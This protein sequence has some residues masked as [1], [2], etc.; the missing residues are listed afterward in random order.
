MPDFRPRGALTTVF[1][2]FAPRQEGGG[3]DLDSRPIAVFSLQANEWFGDARTAAK[4]P[5]PGPA[6]SGDA[7]AGADCRLSGGRPSRCRSIDRGR[8]LPQ[9]ER[10]G[11]PGR[12][13]RLAD[14]T[15]RRMC[16]VLSRASRRVA[17]YAAAPSRLYPRPPRR[18]RCVACGGRVRR[19]CPQG[20]ERAGARAA[21]TFLTT[22]RDRSGLSACD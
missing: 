8:H 10:A 9:R 17:R 1:E 7:G 5:T 21:S 16:V 22:P 11:R 4:I 3:T 13:D 6:R 2:K 20:F 12:P 18:T 14:H 15:C 19:R